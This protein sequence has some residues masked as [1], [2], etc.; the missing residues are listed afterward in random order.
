MRT[1]LISD[2]HGNYDGLLAVLED[3]ARLR[4]D[5]ILCLG[6]LVDGGH[7]GPEVVALLRERAVPTVQGNHDEWPSTTLPL[8]TTEYLRSLPEQIVEGDILYTHTSPR[9][10]KD[11]IKEP[12]EAWNVFEESSYRRI[13]VGDVHIPLLFGQKCKEWVSATSYDIPYRQEFPLDP[14]D[15]Y[16]VCVGSIGYSRD[17]YDLL[18]YAIYDNDRDTLLF[19]ALDGPIL[20]F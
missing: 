16:I 11:K 20:H 8:D 12:I 14:D 9:H 15:R 2:I 5:R 17:A 4:C 13:F 1:A 3:I 6:D 18:R 19:R 10:K 7:Y